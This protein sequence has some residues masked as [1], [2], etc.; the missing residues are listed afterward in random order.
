[1][2]NFFRSNKLILQPGLYIHETLSAPEFKKTVLEME[3]QL[4]CITASADVKEYPKILFL[5][6]GSCIPNKTRNTSGILLEIG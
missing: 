3:D 5:G 4:N 6:T 1:M 2:L